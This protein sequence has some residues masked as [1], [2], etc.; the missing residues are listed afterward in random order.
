MRI[1]FSGEKYPGVVGAYDFFDYD[2]DYLSLNRSIT[3]TIL[4]TI[5]DYNYDYDYKNKNIKK[6]IHI[7]ISETYIKMYV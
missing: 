5:S 2:Y 7:F 6:S 4:I 3:I 1:L